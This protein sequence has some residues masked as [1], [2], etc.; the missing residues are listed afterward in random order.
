MRTWQVA[1]RGQ[2]P[3][4]LLDAMTAEVER[5]TAHWERM[6]SLAA[7]RRWMQLVVEEDGRLVGF[8]T[9][10]PVESED[11]PGTG[12]LYAIY[13]DPDHWDHGHGRELIGAAVEQIT[14]AGY[15]DAVLW[16]LESNAR[17]RRFYEVAGWHLDG[18]RKTEHRG[19]VPLH[20]IR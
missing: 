2:L 3:D 15:G 20:E 4:D 16:V 7:E 9:C 5:R 19:D 14:A 10:G 8:A 17:A 18:G 6:I 1:Y 12:E 11:A 13:V